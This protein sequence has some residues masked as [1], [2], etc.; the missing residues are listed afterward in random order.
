MVVLTRSNKVGYIFH[1]TRSSQDKVCIITY[2]K[3]KALPIL[4]KVLIV[5][6]DVKKKCASI[7]VQSPSTPRWS[8]KKN[9]TALPTDTT[10]SLP[11]LLKRDM[12]VQICCQ[13]C[14]KV[15]RKL[16]ALLQDDCGEWWSITTLS[17]KVS[18]KYV[19]LY[20]RHKQ[21]YPPP[22]HHLAYPAQFSPFHQIN[23]KAF[24]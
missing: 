13:E 9:D 19:F 5:P 20:L 21:K 1:Q 4:S 16:W 7:L 3:W 12:Y 8:F 2:D 18:S 10:V 14:Y 22:H 24:Y 23:R 11:L 6:N 17:N 15:S